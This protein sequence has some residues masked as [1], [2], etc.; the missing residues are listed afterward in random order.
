MRVYLV[1]HGEALPKDVDPGRGLSDVGRRGAEKVAAFLERQAIEVEAVWE[2]GKKR[3][4]Q[5]AEIMASAVRSKEGVVCQ[6]GMAP[7]DPVVPIVE[8]LASL[9]GD[10]V[11]VGHLPF[12]SILASQLILGRAEPDV[13]NFPAATLVCL[14]RGPSGRWAVSW[15]V[16]PDLL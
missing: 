10:Y 11:L 16:T 15:M 4:T 14:E 2:S 7:N 12:L 5:T 13:V 6:S 1:R 9:E 3:A 8:K